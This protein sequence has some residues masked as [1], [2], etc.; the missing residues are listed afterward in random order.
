MATV[1]SMLLNADGRYHDMHNRFRAV[2]LVNSGRV[3]VIEWWD[4]K[5]SVRAQDRVFRVPALMIYHFY[6]NIRNK[7]L[8]ANFSRENLFRRDGYHCLYCGNSFSERQLTIDHIVPRFQGG[9]T[10]WLNCATA[11]KKCNN[12]KDNRT[13]KEARMPLLKEPYAPKQQAFDSFSIKKVSG[14]IHESWAP[15][16]DERQ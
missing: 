8:H 15:Y 6:I 4:E 7:Y 1:R 16:I 11:C 14:M 5:Y 12:K 2:A 9:K 3:T 13:P 10:T